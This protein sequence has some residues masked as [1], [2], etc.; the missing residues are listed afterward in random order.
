MMKYSA[1]SL[2]AILLHIYLFMLLL[3][4]LGDEKTKNNGKHQNLREAPC[5]W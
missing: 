2:S 3:L 1:R 4:I 5:T